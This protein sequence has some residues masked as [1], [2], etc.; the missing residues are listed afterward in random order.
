[1]SLLDV[2]Y[3]DV[4]HELCLQRGLALL[5]TVDQAPSGFASSR[6][7]TV[8]VNLDVVRPWA[9]KD[10]SRRQRITSGELVVRAPLDSVDGDLDA[11]AELLVQVLTRASAKAA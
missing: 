7:R 4:L 8:L 2:T 6:A 9:I 11:A 10:A 3:L 5:L 1:M